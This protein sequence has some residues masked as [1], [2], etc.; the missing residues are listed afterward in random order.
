MSGIISSFRAFEQRFEGAP[1]L[2]NPKDERLK[3]LKR[4]FERGGVVSLSAAKS[5]DWPSMSYP[6]KKRLETQVKELQ[7]LA[8][9]FAGKK[10]SWGKELSNAKLYKLKSHAKKFADPLYWKHQGKRIMDKNYRAAAQSVQMPTEIVSDKRYRP[11]FDMFVNNPE[12]RN[13]LVETV[14][15][16]VVYK[17]NKKL[18]RYSDE[19]QGLRKDVSSSQ[20]KE[21]SEKLGEI[22]QD[23]AMLNVLLKWASP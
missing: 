14:S 1:F 6:S 9:N 4:Y 13:Q 7:E 21:A 22:Q 15:T 5:G 20:L 11:M 3:A 10:K 23:I 16:S 12:Y 2:Q 17:K 8:D 19:L 18:A